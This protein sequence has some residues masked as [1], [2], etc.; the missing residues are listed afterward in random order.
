MKN[1]IWKSALF[2]SMIA[3]LLIGCGG[4][5]NM[6]KNIEE[7]GAEGSPDPLIVRGDQVELTVTGK[8]P[9]K[10]FHKKVRVEATPV[11]VYPGGETAFK[12]VE[13]QGED[14]AGNGEVIRFISSQDGPN[15]ENNYF[16][17]TLMHF[18]QFFK[19]HFVMCMYV[20]FRFHACIT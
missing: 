7:L 17:G 8:F 12:M 1:P 4:L 14:A 18:K 16:D 13:Y 2:F 6:E 20:I 3:L 19:N 9:E 15:I 5:G 11:L 10:Y